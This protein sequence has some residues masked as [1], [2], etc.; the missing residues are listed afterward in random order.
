MFEFSLLRKVEILIDVCLAV[1]FLH[2]EEILHCD[3]KPA[4]IL[5]TADGKAK[6]ADLGE[7]KQITIPRLGGTVNLY[8][9][10][11]PLYM[12]PEMVIPGL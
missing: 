3:I 4:N 1:W 8:A 6:L 11:T 7:A 9:V 2:D 5:L 12:S 10:G